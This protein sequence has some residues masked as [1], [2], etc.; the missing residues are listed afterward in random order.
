MCAQPAAAAWAHPGVEGGER[1]GEGSGRE[2]MAAQLDPCVHRADG[3][4]VLAV[5][6]LDAHIPPL[7]P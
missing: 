2:R 3:V 4:L 1:R 6:V 7:D 5:M